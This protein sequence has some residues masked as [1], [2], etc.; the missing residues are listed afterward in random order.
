MI[1]G[2]RCFDRRGGEVILWRYP[3][4][5]FFHNLKSRELDLVVESKRSGDSNPDRYDF[6]SICRNPVSVQ[7]FIAFYSEYRTRGSTSYAKVTCKD[8]DV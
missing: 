1:E 5:C 7:A 6:G 2:V 4:T 8:Y 3:W